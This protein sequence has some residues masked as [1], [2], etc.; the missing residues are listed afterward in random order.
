M[1]IVQI[2]TSDIVGGA[3][4]AAHRLHKGFIHS[5]VNSRLLVMNKTSSDNNIYA[6]TLSKLKEKAAGNFVLSLIQEQYIKMNRTN[7]SNTIF[8]IPYPGYDLSSI[9]MVREADII[10][11]HW[12]ARFQS[13]LTLRKLFSL[14]KPVVWTLHD[15]WAFTGGCH[16]SAG[17]DKYKS[18]CSNCPQLAHD[19]YDIAHAVLKDKLE[20][21]S[22]ADLTI[23]TPSRWLASCVRE[24]KLFKNMRIETIPNSL[25]TDL[26]IPISKADAKKK[27]G[28]A[29]DSVTILFSAERG[30]EKRKGFMELFNAIKY[31]SENS[32]FRSLINEN[33]LKLICFGKPSD[34]LNLLGIT[35][36]FLGYI[37][38]D[39]MI[40][41]AYSAAD[42]FILPSLEDNLPNTL[43]ES[44]S[45][46]TPVVAFNIGGIPDVIV[47]G[48]TGRLIPS[49]DT[50]DMGKAIMD[51]IFNARKL[52]LM[53]ENCRSVIEKGYHLKGQATQYLELYRE[54]IKGSR[55]SFND[56][57]VAQE[58]GNIIDTIEANLEI[59]VGPN[60]QHIYDHYF[61]KAINVLIEARDKLRA[62]KDDLKAQRNA[63]RAERNLLLNSLSWK[64]TSPLRVVEKFF[65]RD[66]K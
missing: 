1:R 29:P 42:I 17:C 34:N 58:Q 66:K 49:G 56:T 26:F 22:G 61:Q 31:C 18:T 33:K 54:L 21:F 48:E 23:V 53:G 14:G 60:F 65:Q 7:L 28:L 9:N 55:A 27:F 30:F 19:P 39:E 6:A 59:V 45:C 8:T 38:S 2:N 3:A 63:L 62:E 5:G 51:L 11:L 36:V 4:R 64:V 24:S 20:L 43:L 32:A 52:K 15:Q 10:N 40:R 37:N 16:Y 25:E 44:M 57:P 47:D 12:I 50:S 35:V 41:D 13:P 46:G